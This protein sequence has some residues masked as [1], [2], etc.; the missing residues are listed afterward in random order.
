MVCNRVA[1]GLILVYLAMLPG[2]AAMALEQPAFEVIDRVGEVEIRQYQ[3]YLV[4]RTNIAGDFSGAGN[5]AFRRLAGY[6]FGDNATSEKIAMTA[7]VMQYPQ[8]ESESSYWFTFM[9][10][11]A[12]TLD[13]LPRP[14]DGNVELTNK[15]AQTLAALRY[16]GGWSEKKFRQQADIL[17]SALRSDSRYVTVGT[18]MWARYNPPF[19]PSFLRTNEVLIEVRPVSALPSDLR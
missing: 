16:R 2:G 7:P 1:V 5:Q 10:P 6:I 18:T 11:A 4:A 15:P 8:D 19:V 17:L 9:M 3:P 12:Y 13:D 14:A